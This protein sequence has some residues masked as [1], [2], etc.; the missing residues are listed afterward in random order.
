MVVRLEAPL[1]WALVAMVM[2]HQAETGNWLVIRCEARVR[3]ATV[4]MV[5]L[6]LYEAVCG[7]P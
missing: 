7:A 3:Q 6:H 5:L 2:L 1:E 4:A